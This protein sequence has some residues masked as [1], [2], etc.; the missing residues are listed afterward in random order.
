[1]IL[2]VRY[3]Q[4]SL[5][6][7]RADAGVNDLKLWGIHSLRR[8]VISVNFDFDDLKMKGIY[9]RR[10]SDFSYFLKLII[11]EY[12]VYTIR[13]SLTNNGLWEV[14]DFII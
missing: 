10:F 6:R 5:Y 2:I 1:M 8:L 12:S 3:T 4:L 13:D 9:N 14:H 7:K 11:S